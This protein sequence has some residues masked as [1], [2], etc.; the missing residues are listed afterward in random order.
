MSLEK[1]YYK[2]TEGYAPNKMLL[3]LFK[4]N[5]SLNI[6]SAMDIGCGAGRDTCFLIKRGAKV[7]AIDKENTKEIIIN[8]LSED[9]LGRLEFVQGD[10]LNY[11]FKKYDLIN[12][13]HKNVADCFA[14]PSKKLI[15]VPEFQYNSNTEQ[16]IVLVNKKN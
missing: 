16:H 10:I 5:H 1:I 15:F 8:K 3:Q 13:P 11:N 6:S 9:E 4:E 12:L 7:V 2:V 14:I